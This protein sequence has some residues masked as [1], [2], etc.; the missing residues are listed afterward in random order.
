MKAWKILGYLGLLPFIISLYLSTEKL[1]F[2]ISTKHVFIAY[3]AVILSFIAGTLWRRDSQTYLDK[4]NIISNLFSLLAFTSLLLD[5]KIALIILGVSFMLLFFYEK[6]LGKQ[7][8]LLTDYMNMRFW[9]TLIVALLHIT[10]Y[11]LWFG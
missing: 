2:G 8:K 6:S 9:L 3:S 1:F 7:S 5:Q 11:S 10:A 4:Q